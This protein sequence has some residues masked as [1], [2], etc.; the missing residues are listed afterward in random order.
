MKKV[1]IIIPAYNE[2][3]S[4]LRTVK[5]IQDFKKKNHLSF[6]L[7]YLVVND[8]S[9]DSTALILDQNKL[10]HV[11][12]IR[13]LGIGGAVQT[14]YIYAERYGYDAAVQFDGDGQHDIASIVDLVS[15]VLNGECE[16]VI[17]SRFI[18]KQK[19]NFK[20]TFMRRFGIN[21]ISNLIK[22]T[23]GKRIY[24]TTSGYRVANRD[25]ISYFSKRYPVAYPEPEMIVRV[26]KKGYRVE[27]I[28]ANM[29]ERLE[30]VSSI[31]PLKSITYMID[32]L[33]SILMAALM[34]EN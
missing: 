23:T 32:V 5:S 34:K 3:G 31:S 25:I 6:Q 19:E 15:P 22:L 30:G 21:M 10:H 18:D 26:L 7:D 13:N 9:K 2:E 29:F 4:I 27:E 11:D 8:G 16:F 33:A 24:D 20:S 1:L 12:L 14:G 17:G 28:S